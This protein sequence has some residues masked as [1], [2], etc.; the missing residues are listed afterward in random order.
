MAAEPQPP[1]T[2]QLSDERVIVGARASRRVPGS[3]HDQSPLLP[4]NV[5]LVIAD[6]NGRV[7]GLGAVADQ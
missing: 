5:L 4:V 6:D 2:G 7:T 3:R 1:P